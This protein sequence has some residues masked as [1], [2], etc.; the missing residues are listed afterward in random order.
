LLKR[1]EEGQALEERLSP[2]IVSKIYQMNDLIN[3]SFLAK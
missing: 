1:E 2:A 3:I